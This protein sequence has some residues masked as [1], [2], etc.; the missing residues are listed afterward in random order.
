MSDI[1]TLI[2]DFGGVLVN[3]DKQL[4]LDT[5]KKLGVYELEKLISKY[6]Q[7][8][9]LQDLEVGKITAKGFRDELRKLSQ[10]N[11]TDAQIDAAWNIFLLDIPAFKLDLLLELRKKYRVIMLSNTNELHFEQVAIN[12]FKKNGLAL[13]DYFDKCYLSYKIG[14]AKPN[15]DIFHHRYNYQ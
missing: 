15:E 5:F 13:D 11:L 2:F 10:Q 12:E 8:G 1:K 6:A 3:L 4:C 14:M 7:S 9:F